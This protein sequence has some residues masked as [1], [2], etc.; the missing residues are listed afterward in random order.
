MRAAR[1]RHRLDRALLPYSAL[2][3]AW[4]AWQ[5]I[6]SLRTGAGVDIVSFLT[7]AQALNDG[8][9]HGMY[10]LPV[11]AHAQA[12]VLGYWPQHATGFP[13]VFV[14]PPLVAEALRP[15]AL[16]P[17]AVAEA[18]VLLTSLLALVGVGLVVARS[19]PASVVGERRVALACAV[20]A[21]TAAAVGLSL[22][23]WGPLLLLATVVGG[24]QLRRRP[25]LAGVILSALL[26]KPQDVWLVVPAL[27]LARA[28][29]PLAGF[30]AGATVWV[31]STLLI[32]GPAGTVDLFHLVTGDR[33]SVWS[34]Y[35]AG[36]PGALTW[37]TG[38][39][40][41]ATAISAVSAALV[42]W[43]MWRLRRRLRD[44]V[45]AA[46]ALGLVASLLCAPHVFDHDLVLAGAAAA[47]WAHRS[48]SVA[49]V[50]ALALN[51]AASLD[52]VITSPAA[53]LSAL[54][55][56]CVFC[57]MGLGMRHVTI[58]GRRHLK[59][60]AALPAALTTLPAPTRAPAVP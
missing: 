29:R 39:A 4:L 37:L 50:T 1:L 49:L 21:S 52:A 54:A 30:A 46:V 53:H 42:V 8:Q 36:L 51:A 56:A 58:V 13:S 44:D 40:R 2:L 20:S 5:P 3:V 45:Q 47:L 16:L 23:Q 34:Q 48:P 6:R 22:G 32:A 14:N 17:L 7:G 27:V 55:L 10:T 41:A 38:T 9:A 33:Y 26:V 35:T 60:G 24:A 28:W 19:L 31:A 43:V 18:C 25:L 59:V 15:L 12:Q 11:Q 57:A